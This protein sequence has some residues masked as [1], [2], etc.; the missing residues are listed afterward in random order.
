MAGGMGERCRRI[1]VVHKAFWVVNKAKRRNKKKQMQKRKVISYEYL[2][3]DS[4]EEKV[5]DNI[6][7][8]IVAIH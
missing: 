3:A 2:M 7:W 5:E 1:N 6:L 4:S 8:L